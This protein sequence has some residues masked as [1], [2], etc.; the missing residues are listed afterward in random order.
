MPKLALIWEN[1]FNRKILNNLAKWKDSS[2]RKPLILRGARQVGKTSVVELFAKKNY[3]KFV[4]LNLEQVLQRNFYSQVA[5]VDEFV[6]SVRVDK[7]IKITA[8]DTLIFIDEI[9]N[10]PN[11]LELLRFFY[12]DYPDLHVIAAGSLLEKMIEQK[13]PSIPVGR[14]SY[15]YMYPLDFFEYLEAMGEQ[16]LLLVLK[17]LSFGE[18]VSANIHQLALDHFQKYMLVGGMPEI[19]AQYTQSTD[20]AQINQVFSDIITSYADDI[21]KYAINSDAQY[22]DHVLLN[23]H[24]VAGQ[25]YKYS[26]FAGTRSSNKEI[27]PAFRSL[28][29]VML[30]TQ[31]TATKSI[32]LPVVS[33]LYRPKKMVFLDVGLVN[34]QSCIQDYIFT[35]HKLA[36]IFKGRI[37]E[38]VVGQNL[39]AQGVNAKVKLNYWSPG[40]E[41]SAAEVDFCFAHQGKIIG[42][43]VKS[44]SAGKLRSLFVFADKVV[45]HQLVRFHTGHLMKE[46]L[47][48]DHKNYQLLSIPLYL[49]SRF[50]ELLEK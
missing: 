17:Q 36:D 4:Q 32:R 47:I 28:E 38:Q 29:Q 9:Q 20:L 15:A 35:K 27:G 39:I 45:D 13:K 34:F 46:E 23:A 8:G 41:I 31:V 5:S 12:E 3:T 50:F 10:C 49:V 22:L 11:L 6:R 33:Q 18:G 14:V 2:Q 43:E 37:V 42:I 16:E 48:F 26:N 7:R 25:I 21:L 19:V 40:K 24:T 1:M 44:G 30:L